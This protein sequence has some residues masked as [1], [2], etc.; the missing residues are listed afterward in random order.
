MSIRGSTLPPGEL[1]LLYQEYKERE[2]ANVRMS[3]FLNFPDHLL[4]PTSETTL[5]KGRAFDLQEAAFAE[6]KCSWN[7]KGQILKEARDRVSALTGDWNEDREDRDHVPPR[8]SYGDIGLGG[9]KGVGSDR[10]LEEVKGT[11]GEETRPPGPQEGK[12][13]ETAKHPLIIPGSILGAGPSPADSLWLLTWAHQATLGI[14]LFTLRL[15]PS[16]TAVWSAQKEWRS[17]LS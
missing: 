13:P 1:V 11:W 14:Q 12:C 15:G 2:T 7:S 4:K 5:S 8:E 16:L 6:G 3:L 10:T 9:K 17:P